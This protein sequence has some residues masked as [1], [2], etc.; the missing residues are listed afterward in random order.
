M[1]EETKT[2]LI[3]SLLK[4]YAVFATSILTAIIFVDYVNVPDPATF[5]AFLICLPT[6]VYLWSLVIRK[7]T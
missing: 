7:R 3:Y 6:P 1:P 4:W 5:I 2:L